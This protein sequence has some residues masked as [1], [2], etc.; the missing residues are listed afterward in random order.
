MNIPLPDP[1]AYLLTWT[2]YGTRLP[3]DERGWVDRGHGLQLPNGPLEAWSNE[4]LAHSPVILNNDER[5]LIDEI[6]RKHCEMRRWPLHAVNVRTNH[7]HVVVT[8]KIDPDDT[9]E[10]FK[11]WGTRKLKLLRN[12][13]PKHWWTR[14]QS[15]GYL[16]TD[17]E[18][19]CAVNYV[20]NCQ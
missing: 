19:L 10:Q 16:N 11:A 18:F 17:D 5:A 14:G 4:R 3:G 6:I 8:S 13:P 12:P 9:A 7:V 15:T 20:L 2:T 1:L